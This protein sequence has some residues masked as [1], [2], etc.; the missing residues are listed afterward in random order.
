MGPGTQRAPCLPQCKLF[1]LQHTWARPYLLC[2]RH[3]REPVLVSPAAPEVQ[4]LEP[5]VKGESA[6]I[7]KFITELP[8]T[9]NNSPY[10]GPAFKEPYYELEIRQGDGPWTPQGKQ[11][12]SSV[13][14]KK[15]IVRRRPPLPLRRRRRVLTRRAH[16]AASAPLPSARAPPTFSACALCTTTW[17]QSGLRSRRRCA[18]AT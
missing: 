16:R 1:P 14:R 8:S 18:T 12:R 10:C 9:L 2:P 15:H 5:T 3:P 6:A 7:L 17:P 11:I 4:S 13:V